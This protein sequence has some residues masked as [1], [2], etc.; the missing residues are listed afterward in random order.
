M[1]TS[2]AERE[3]IYGKTD[4]ECAGTMEYQSSA[5]SGSEGGA[6]QRGG[7][8]K[9]RR[10]L[11]PRSTSPFARMLLLRRAEGVNSEEADPSSIHEGCSMDE[12]S[13]TCAGFCRGFGY[14]SV[15]KSRH[16][17]PPPK[18]QTGRLRDHSCGD[19]C[20]RSTAALNGDSHN[21]IVGEFRSI[22]LRGRISLVSCRRT[23][24][25]RPLLVKDGFGS[26]PGIDIPAR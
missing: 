6:R 24:N 11:S 10:V 2:L 26:R 16:R 17:F 3:H 9:E 21:D 18:R 25:H 13:F 20:L 15:D 12:V 14:P 19:P 8:K 4:F 22:S 23:A 7:Q 5:R 1:R